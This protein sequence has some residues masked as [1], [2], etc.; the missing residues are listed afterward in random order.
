MIS[1]LL[2]PRRLSFL[3]FD[4]ECLLKGL[5]FAE[6]LKVDSKYSVK[7]ELS[8]SILTYT[9]QLVLSLET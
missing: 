3:Q 5:L 2:V 6:F 4:L 9:S 7:V 1:K 8:E